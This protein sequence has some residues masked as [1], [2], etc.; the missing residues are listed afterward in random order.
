MKADLIVLGIE[1][2]CDETSASILINGEIRSNRIATQD[3]HVKYGGVVPELASRAH[4]SNIVPVVDQAL[5]EAGVRPDQ[6][7][8]IAYTRG[9][10][11][12]GALLVGASFA[13]AMALALNVP[14][15]EVHHMHAHIHSLFIQDKKVSPLPF[16]F[17]CMTVSGG[18]TQLIKV[19]APFEF[20]LLGETLDDA[21]GEAFDKIGKLM[22]L[23]YPAG[24]QIDAL[25]KSGNSHAFIFPIPTVDGLNFSFSGLKTSLLNFLRRETEKNPNFIHENL[26]DLCASVQHTIVKILT[27]KLKLAMKQES[28]NCFGIAGGVSA[29][30]CLRETLQTIAIENAWSC[31]LPAREY[32][33]DNAAMVAVT[34][35]LS[36]HAQRIGNH[37]NT[38]DA[39]LPFGF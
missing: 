13:K 11:L 35:Y 18:H 12:L 15:I 2:S 4:Q 29:N 34:G 9:P 33:T 14:L 32:T 3:V 22:G 6:L 23:P 38:A 30:S 10:G 24:P 17:L 7:T 5:H 36:W 25:A 1:S 8:A 27:E 26:A 20:E 28:L 37:A 39:N 19:K 16:P 21:A 31:T